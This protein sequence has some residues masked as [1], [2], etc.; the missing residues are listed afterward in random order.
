MKVGI[1]GTGVVGQQLAAALSSKGHEV[2]IGTRD[3]ER[4]L[5]N[6][7]SGGSG[8]QNFA[9]WR[10]EHPDIGLGS[11]A[12]AAAHGELL[13]NATGGG[14][15]LEALHSAGAAHLGSKV[16][17]DVANDLDFSQG[18]PPRTR[19]SD[20]PG[21]SVGEQIQAAFPALKVVKSLNTMSA[22]VMAQPSLVGSGDSTVF[23]NG[24][25]AGAKQ[26]VTDLLHSLG[27][28][29]VMDLG[30]ITASRAVELLLP[31]WLRSWGVV[32]NAPFNFKIVR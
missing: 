5:A 16:L 4:T 27:W 1:F 11:F 2:M 22:Y 17:I 12:E 29:D 9:Q 26:T 32:G 20:Q 8:G 23:V 19:T 7:A 10:G 25:D 18:M 28:T 24:N 3:V 21:S 6:T 31:I 14:V 30:D 13:I 15:S